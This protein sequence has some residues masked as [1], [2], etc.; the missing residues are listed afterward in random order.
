[1][2][3]SRGMGIES[4]PGHRVS[5]ELSRGTS[6]IPLTTSGAW[7]LGSEDSVCG[8]Q[9]LVNFLH[10]SPLQRRLGRS[11]VDVSLISCL[12]LSAEELAWKSL[13]WKLSS[14]SSSPS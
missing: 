5:V 7:M 6:T 2:Q 11:Q 10:F 4:L 12:P 13:V 9:D 1:M 3:L 8:K 14:L